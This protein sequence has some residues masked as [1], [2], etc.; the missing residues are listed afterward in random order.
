MR[1]PSLSLTV[2]A[3]VKLIIVKLVGDKRQD[4]LRC[5]RISLALAELCL[6]AEKAKWVAFRWH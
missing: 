2:L 6:H 3:P 1:D 4:V 5:L